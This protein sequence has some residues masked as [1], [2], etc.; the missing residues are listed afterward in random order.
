[1]D[2]LSDEL[3]EPGSTSRRLLERSARTSPL[4]LPC[5]APA[6]L[7]SQARQLDGLAELILGR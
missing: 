2:V 4:P 3:H 1:M 6:L 5:G 7:G